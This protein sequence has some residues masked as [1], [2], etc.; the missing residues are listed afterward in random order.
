MHESNTNQNRIVT[1]QPSTELPASFSASPRIHPS[2]V[3][4]DPTTGLMTAASSDLTGHSTALQEE[5]TPASLQGSTAH[6]AWD[7]CRTSDSGS[8]TIETHSTHKQ[9]EATS[10]PAAHNG[11]VSNPL[12]KQAPCPAGHLPCYPFLHSVNGDGA[13]SPAEVETMKKGTA[14]RAGIVIKDAYEFRLNERGQG[15]IPGG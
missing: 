13:T 4:A 2:S 10:H 11:L 14:G 3:P 5:Q 1:S 9:A 15:H 6:A 7:E 8:G 12:K